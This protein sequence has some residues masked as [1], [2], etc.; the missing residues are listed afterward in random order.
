MI[1]K[2]AKYI[3]EYKKATILTPIY[4]IGEVLMEVLIPLVMAAIIDNGLNGNN[5]Q[6]DLGYVVKV[7]SLMF[8][9]AVASL[10]FGTMSGFK[11]AEAS[12]GFAKNLRQAIYN[13]IQ[14]FSFS[15]IDKFSTSSLVTR[16]TTDV[17][18]IQNAFQMVIRMAVRSPMMMI[19]SFI[20]AYRISNSLSLVFLVAVPFLAIAIGAI[21]VSTFPKFRLMFEKYDVLNRVVQENVGAIRVVKAYTREDH[22]VEKFHNAADDIYKTSVAAEKI[23]ALNS[24]VMMFSMYACI[25]AICW[26][27]S[28][29]IVHGDLSTGEFM[30]LLTY[31]MSI[32][33]SLM[34]LSIFFLMIVMSQA[35]GKRICEVLDEVPDL[36]NPGSPVMSVKDGSIEFDNVSFSYYKN[37]KKLH[38]QNTSIKIES[39]KTV[40]ILGGT[41]S[42]K[43]TF[44]SLIPR[45]YDVTSGSVKVGGVDV[46]EYDIETLRNSV[47]M[48]LQNNVLFSGSISDNIRWGDEE[49]SQE[50]IEKMCQ[51]AC[52]DE[53]V[54]E[55]EDGYNTEL[56]QGGVNVSGGQ[57]QRLCIA[58]A[59]IKKPKILILDDSTS[60]VDMNTDARIRKSF[61]E[62]I[63]N[64]T[65]LIIAQRISSVQDADMIIVMDNGSISAVGTHEELLKTSPIYKETFETQTKAKEAE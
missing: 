36:A 18:T 35:S 30:S 3:G 63:P 56:G 58:R 27:A 22:E 52:A 46:R 16:L 60:A 43:T 13:K 54:K 20:M 49:A 6:G 65:K 17:T 62:E 39:G 44:V 37:K 28:T 53:F 19:F 26:F 42:G 32:L 55:R 64:T 34:M 61:K 38:L 57:K 14:T 59:L 10:F 45:L 7:G 2:L 51:L 5:G 4:M 25:L 8:L 50:E 23:I 24:P 33:S 48:V 47:A 21:M 9:M 12:A 15:N 29:Q 41:G 31:I 1:K 40:G 11:G